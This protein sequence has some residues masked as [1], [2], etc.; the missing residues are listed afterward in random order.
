MKTNPLQNPKVVAVLVVAATVALFFQ[1]RPVPVSSKSSKPAKSA[2]AAGKTKQVASASSPSSDSSSWIDPGGQLDPA[3]FQSRLAQWVDSPARDPFGFYPKPKSNS[4]SVTNA[5]Q[6]LRLTAIWRQTGQ[7]LA[8]INNA[9]VA[10]GS[11]ILGYRLEQIEA[12]QVRVSGPRGT[13]QVALAEF[14]AT[15]AA[16]GTSNTAPAVATIPPGSTRGG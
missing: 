14:D 5:S 1:L 6:V 9:V 10:E 8:V 13:E 12:N 15:P 7:R 11:D 2:V 4:G 16:R 3:F